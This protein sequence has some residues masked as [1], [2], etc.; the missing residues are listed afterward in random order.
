MNNCADSSFYGNSAV[1]HDLIA[2]VEAKSFPNDNVPAWSI[3]LVQH[4]LD[5]LGALVDDMRGSLGI[6]FS[7]Y[8]NTMFV[9]FSLFA[10]FLSQAFVQMSIT[11]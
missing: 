10:T 11:S 4:L 9:T 3:A 7:V 2:D 5:R 8:I 1:R 6:V